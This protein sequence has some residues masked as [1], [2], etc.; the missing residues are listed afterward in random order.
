MNAPTQ[1]QIVADFVAGSGRAGRLRRRMAAN[2]H[3][4]WLL[5]LILHSFARY[6]AHAELS[7]LESDIIDAFKR[8]GYEDK[9]LVRQGQLALT[10][11]RS[12]RDELFEPGYAGLTTDTPYTRAQLAADAPRL[13]KT[14]L[15]QPNTTVIDVEGIHAGR[16]KLADVRLP[17]D[18]VLRQHASSL[19]VAVEPSARSAAKVSTAS[20][21]IKATKFRCNQ[22]EKDSVFDPKAE[23]YFLFGSTTGGTAALTTRSKIFDGVDNGQTVTFPSVDGLMW[24]MN[25]HAEPLPAGEIG[26][27]VTAI[28]HDSGDTAQIQKDVAAAFATASAILT[29]TGAAAW[30][31]AVTMAVG[32]VVGWLIGIA[33]DD[34]VGETAFT[35]D[36]PLLAKQ[37]SSVGATM[38]TERRIT[39]GADDL[40]ITI[41]STRET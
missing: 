5:A 17:S 4:N 38:P 2:Q 20:Y 40:T 36:G 18:A 9:D 24:G 6:A 7:D 34:P 31:A 10:L 26:L 32:G 11:T 19:T 30:I 15:A 16:S 21:S 3:R 1:E 39:N 13:L 22:R 12:V 14:T 8:H 27:L 33:A 35:F 37:L 23:Y 29:L 25:G 41:M 28:E